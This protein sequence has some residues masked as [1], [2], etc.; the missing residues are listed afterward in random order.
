MS[1]YL[2]IRSQEFHDIMFNNKKNEEEDYSFEFYEER[3]SS[4]DA[5]VNFIQSNKKGY[6]GNGT[7]YISGSEETPFPIT[8]ERIFQIPKCTEYKKLGFV[9]GGNASIINSADF[10]ISLHRVAGAIF[11]ATEYIPLSSIPKLIEFHTATILTPKEDGSLE[12]ITKFF[13]RN[14]E[15]HEFLPD[16]DIIINIKDKSIRRGAFQPKIESFGSIARRFAEWSYAKEL[17]NQEL[18]E[19]DVF[20]KDGS[21]QTGFKGEIKLALRLYQNALRKKVYVTGVSKSCRLLTNQGDSLIS[22]IDL[23]GNQ[24]FPEK[25]WYY[26]PIYKITRA[27]NQADLFFVKLHKFA[28]CPFRFDIYLK[29]SQTLDRDERELIIS[30]L[31][32]NAIE[33]T[34]PGYPYGLIKVDQMSRVAYREIDGQKVMVLAEFDKKHYEKFILPRLRSVEA[35]DILNKIKKN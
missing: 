9:D 22:I 5:C 19:G 31:S 10:N 24:K 6:A 21:L 11:Q 23:I 15:H 1:F 17:I 7:P 29:Q 33:L 28:Y 26:H 3:K 25:A 32:S 13:P 2:C 18:D 8:A 20:C 12:Y 35:H 4:I 34:F 16:N 30:N 27:D 14:S